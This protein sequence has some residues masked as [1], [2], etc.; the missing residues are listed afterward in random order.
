MFTKSMA[1]AT[2]KKNKK[3]KTTVTAV[4]D[5]PQES[6]EE[7]IAVVRMSSS[8]I[9]NGNDSDSDEYVKKTTLHK[10]ISSLT[11]MSMMPPV[12]K[13]GLMHLL[14]TLALQF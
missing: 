7:F 3:A 9:G 6:G 12:V 2:K 13:L 1:L 4:V 8:I 11:V 10:N 5:E 14:T